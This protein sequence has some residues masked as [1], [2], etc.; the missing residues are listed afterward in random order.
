[1]TEPIHGDSLKRLIQD[2][3]PGARLLRT[4]PLRGGSSAQMTPFEIALPGGG[5]RKLI[6]RRLGANNI[7]SNR[8][9][10][11]SEFKLLQLLQ[12]TDLPTA[13]PCHLD[14]DGQF[15]V[16]EY[17]DGEA[18]YGPA[19]GKDAARQLADCLAAIHAIDGASLCFVPEQDIALDL[20]LNNTL[21]DIDNTLY[22]DDIR[23]TLKATWPP[24]QANPQTL[25]HGDFWPGNILWKDGQLVAVIDWEDA[26]R[27]D[28][29]SDLAISRLDLRMIYGVDAMDAFTS[30]YET[31]ATTTTDTTALPY[32]D[33]YAAL[34]S[35]PHID[36]WGEGWPEL[37]RGD[38]TAHTMKVDYRSFVEQ[39]LEAILLLSPP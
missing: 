20:I 15:M 10:A 11:I 24:P 33:L 38:I 1:M 21:K 34:R 8:Q 26:T 22:F 16:I 36:D 13:A 14:P 30:R 27:G 4:W 9:A 32:W 23:D 2:F 37:G 39:A 31:A 5:T 7:G 12:D 19:D 35:A 6:L 3:A 18:D 17:L 25:L 28:P 29:L